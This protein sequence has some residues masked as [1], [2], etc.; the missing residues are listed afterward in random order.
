MGLRLSDA[1]GI[2]GFEAAVQSLIDFIR[3]ES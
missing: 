1:M 2:A 3:E